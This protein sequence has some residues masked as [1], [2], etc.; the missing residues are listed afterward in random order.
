MIYYFTGTGNSLWTARTL[1]VQLGERTENLATYKDKKLVC[2]DDVIG[3]VCPVYMISLPWFVKQALLNAELNPKAYTFLVATSNN[4]KGGFAAKCMDSLLVRNGSKLMYYFDLQMPGN[5]IESSAE[6]NAQRLAAAPAIVEDIGKQ[7]L[8]RTQNFKSRRKAAKD[9]IVE[10]SWFYKKKRSAAIN[11]V[12]TF[13]ITSD[14]NG[15][16]I[17]ANICPVQNI[18]ITDGKAVHGDIC[19][20]C[21]G[22]VHWCPKHATRPSAEQMRDRSQYHHPEVTTNDLMG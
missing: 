18:S 7:I 11:S 20:A 15:C 9:N 8:A 19:A 17:C 13:E 3:F 5:C 4:G 10:K 1:A 2:Q 22:C 21:Y 16:G 14:C 6:E 12:T